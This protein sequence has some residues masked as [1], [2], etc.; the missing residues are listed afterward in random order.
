MFDTSKVTTLIFDVDDTLYD[1]S[2]GFTAHRNTD[3]ATGFMVDKLN[4]P[5]KEQAKLIRD[6]YFERYHSTA[7]GL[8]IAELE[9][10]LP[11]PP[12]GLSKGQKLFDPEELSTWWA[13]NLDFSL[14]G[15]VDPEL[16]HVLETC[17]KKMIAFSNGPRAYVLRVLSEMG[18]SKVFPE[19]NVFSVNDVLPACKPEPEAFQKVFD[20]IG[21]QHPSECIMIED[22]MKNIRASK[23]L[24]M[25][26]I[27]VVGKGRM[28]M[29][30]KEYN[31]DLANAA[32]AT[33]PGDA[34][35]ITDDSVDI[36]I[37]VVKDMKKAL[38]AL[39]ES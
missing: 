30:Q 7:K 14:L 18:L 34:P 39:W 24:G 29:E 10:R 35:D 5:N 25:S 31:S 32:E 19:E 33:K 27:L 4:F 16:V 6:E 3:G 21:V 20:A 13:E 2:T 22:S 9:G 26:T 1:V 8:Q 15:D 12:G 37:E 28:S 11:I 38:P 36:C 17:P 23:R